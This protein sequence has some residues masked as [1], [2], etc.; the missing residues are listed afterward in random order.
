MKK[1]VNPM[2]IREVMTTNPAC[3]KPTD[4]IDTVAKLMLEHDCGEIPVCEGTRLVGVI[5]DRDITL[6]AVAAGKSPMS[7]TA[8]EVMTRN[9]YSV[10]ENDKLEVAFTI[11]DEKL[12]RRLPVIDA[13][14]AIVGIVSQADLVARV[15]SFKT[16][17][18]MKAVAK[19][20]RK[21]AMV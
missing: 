12:V 17:R 15:P 6:R 8:S 9:V 16:A 5:T 13:N 7:L 1:E 20:T 2:L 18:L 11:M 4:T 14:G 19:K 10:Y 21:H 3:C